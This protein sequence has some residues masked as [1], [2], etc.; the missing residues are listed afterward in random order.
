MIRTIREPVGDSNLPVCLTGRHG[1][2]R[3]ITGG[4]DFL[5]AELAVAEN[6]DESDEH[7]DLRGEEYP[8]G[9]SMQGLCHVG[10][11]MLAW[12]SPDATPDG[13]IARFAI[14]Y[15][16]CNAAIRF[17]SSRCAKGAPIEQ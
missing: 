10:C 3:L 8:A 4:N 2:A 13:A 9:L 14:R 1:D 17:S 11:A 15:G 7:G 5:K 6:S 16:T 12:V